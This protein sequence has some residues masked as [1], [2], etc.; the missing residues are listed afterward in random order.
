MNRF[1]ILQ[2][3]SLTLCFWLIFKL[4]PFHALLVALSTYASSGISEI[5]Y[6]SLVSGFH[7]EEMKD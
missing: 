4:R 6:K 3:L 7:R 2:P 5:L 1:G